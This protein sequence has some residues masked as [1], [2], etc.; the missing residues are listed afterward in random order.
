MERYEG[1]KISERIAIGTILVRHSD[2]GKIAP[3]KISDTEAELSRF[4]KAAAQAAAE[5]RALAEKASRNV[6]RWDAKIFEVHAMMIEDVDYREEVTKTILRQKLCAE[7][8]VALAGGH[9][10]KMFSDMEDEY[11][12]ARSQ[13]VLDVTER[14]LR[15]LRGETEE[16]VETPHILAASD[17]T[18][19]ELMQQNRSNILGIISAHGTPYSHTSILARNMNI[20]A[21]S[22][23]EPET[24]WNGRRAILDG[25]RGVLII[26]PDAETVQKYLR[27]MND[28]ALREQERK[29][30][31]AE[32]PVTKAGRYVPLMA[33]IGNL[34]DL[35]QAAEYGADGVG[36][37]RSEVL[38]MN[39]EALPTEEE[40][41]AFYRKAVET[42]EGR[43]VVIRTVDIGADK[44]AP[45]LHMEDEEN[46]ALGKR[47]IRVSLSNP[48][49]FRTQ[50]RAIFRAGQYG[51]VSVL[52]PMISAEWEMKEIAGLVNE[53]RRELTQEGID[54]TGVKQGIMIETPAAAILSD[55]L[56]EYVDFFSI[57]T[58]DLAQYVLAVDRQNAELTQYY[59][60]R[61]EALM[62][63]ISMTVG[64]AH[65]RGIPVCMCGEL[66]AD[67]NATAMLLELGVDE[68]SVSPSLLPEV[69]RT[70]RE[71]DF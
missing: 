36:L 60:P 49:L 47:G 46:P 68:L 57:G 67:I 30:T 12:R 71:L 41:F 18:P 65:R 5:L 21:I 20:P 13:D 55:R 10:A 59:N 43:S 7:Y 25:A 16:T 8:S 27:L 58:N 69:K 22:G 32:K 51:K 52:Y 63:L 2:F 14:L 15:V 38:F 62:R 48:E 35:E 26:D 19:G 11:F 37:L 23:I 4:E 1:R 70:I 28:N 33:N 64:N 34:S 45:C 44:P 3:V 61:H 9:F 56:S 50:L 66:A 54:T 40:Q 42:M 39:S 53:V 24:S 17:L 29:S 6:G 31:A